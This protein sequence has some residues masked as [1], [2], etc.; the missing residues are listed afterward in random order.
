PPADIAFLESPAR[1]VWIDQQRRAHVW[2]TGTGQPL[3]T[4]LTGSTFELPFLGWKYKLGRDRTRQSIARGIY[5]VQ[6]DAGTDLQ[7]LLAQARPIN[8][9]TVSPDGRRVATGSG[10]GTARVWD[11]ATREPIT[12]PLK[13]PGPVDHVAFSPDGRY[14]VCSDGIRGEGEVD[15]APTGMARVWDAA[16]GDPVTP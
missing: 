1:L 8:W 15:R 4:R 5:R 3:E 14:I 6:H 11:A 2:N 9:V 13:H 12:P 7:P 16:T 10:D